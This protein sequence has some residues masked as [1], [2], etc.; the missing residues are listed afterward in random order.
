[1]E[2]RVAV[3]T[4][5]GFVLEARTAEFEMQLTLLSRDSGGKELPSKHRAFLDAVW[6]RLACLGQ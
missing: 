4:Q 1:M 5:H 3:A 6:H 2:T